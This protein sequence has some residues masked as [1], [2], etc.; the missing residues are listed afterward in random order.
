MAKLRN[1]FLKSKMNKDL[2]SRLVPT[3]EYRDALNITVGKSESASVGTAQ[4]VLG[5]SEI[6]TGGFVG[7]VLNAIGYIKDDSRNIVILFQTTYED[8][9]ETQITPAP[10]TATCRIVLVDFNGT[11]PLQTTL[12]EG[13]W[14]NLATNNQYSITGVNLVEDLL[15]W[16]D[17]RNQPRKINIETALADSAYYKHEHQISVAKYTPVEPIQL[18]KKVQTR[19]TAA[20]TTAVIS[21]AS[22]VGIEVGMFLVANTSP[23][24]NGNQYIQVISK[25]SSNVTVDNGNASFSGVTVANNQDIIFLS[26]TMTDQSSDSTWPGDPDYLEGRYVRFSYRIRYDDNEYSTFAPFTQIC[27]IPKQKGY[28]INGDEQSAFRSTILDFFENNVNNI[29]LLI[30][31]PTIGSK[32]IS[33][34]SVSEI[35]I[36]YKESDSLIVSV[37]E[38]INVSVLQNSIP[39]TNIFNYTYSSEKPYKTLPEAQTTRVYDKVP[40]RARAQEVSGNRVIY[41]NYRDNWTMPNDINYNVAVQAKTS[42][43]NNFIEYPNHTLKQNRNYQVGFILADKYNRQSSV[44]LSSNDTGTSTTGAFFGGSTIYSAYTTDTLVVKSW[45]GNALRV[46]VNSPI[47]ALNDTAAGTPGLYAN[48]ISTGLGFAVTDA[49][50]IT[51]TTYTFTLDNGGGAYPL[52]TQVPTVGSYLRGQFTDYVEVKNITGS[53]SGPYVVTTDG[54]VNDI[55]KY[56]QVNSSVANTKFAYDINPIGW[57]SYKVVVKQQEQEYYNSYLP[58]MLNA[59]PDSQTSD[60]SVKYVQSAVGSVVSLIGSGTILRLTRTES[61]EGIIIGMVATNITTPFTN[62]SPVTVTNVV[63]GTTVDVTVNQ[64]VTAG[65]TQNILF[66]ATQEL[67]EH[68][69][70]TTIFPVNEE[71]KTAHIVLI[72]D[73][74]NKI[75][76]DLT[77]VGPDQKQYRSSVELF[78]R[79]ENF[80]DTYTAPPNNSPVIINPQAVS[81]TTDTITY[82]LPAGNAITRFKSGDAIQ[83]ENGGPSGGTAVYPNGWLK[84]TV[85]VSN[86][87]NPAGTLGTIVFS[88]PQLIYGGGVSSQTD[89]FTFLREENKQYFP[90]RKADTVNTISTARDLDF[91]PNS[92]DNVRGTAALNFY[93]LDTNP[94]V[95]RISTVKG[96]GATAQ[97]MIPFLSV[98]ETKPIE[99]QLDIFW[100]T[101]STGYISDLNADV[102]TGFDGAVSLTNPGYTHRENQDATGSG[103]TTGAANSKFITNTFSS[104]DLNGNIITS[105]TMTLDSVFDFTGSGIDI[106]SRFQLI[107]SGSGGYRLA[108]QDVPFVF[109]NDAE[110][111]EKYTFNIKVTVGTTD[112]ILPIEGRLENIAPFIVN[113]CNHY[114]TQITQ[115]TTLVTTIEAKNGAHQATGASVDTVQSDVFFEILSGDQGYFEIDA[116]S[117]E[118]TTVGIVPIGFYALNIQVTD[119]YNGSPISPVNGSAFTSKTGNCGSQ[120]V[121]ITVGQEQ[122][123]QGYRN[124]QSNILTGIFNFLGT[125]NANQT[126]TPNNINPTGPVTPSGGNEFMHQTDPINTISTKV[127]RPTHLT[128]FNTG[129]SANNV[130][131]ACLYLGPHYV[132]IDTDLNSSTHGLNIDD[133][134]MPAGTSLARLPLGTDDQNGNTGLATLVNNILG[135]DVS[136]SSVSAGPYMNGKSLPQVASSSDPVGLLS[137]QLEISNKIQGTGSWIGGTSFFR[138]VSNGQINLYYKIFYRGST[139]NADGSIDYALNF[140]SS[141]NQVSDMN[142][143]VSSTG[144]TNAAGGNNANNANNPLRTKVFVGNNN[145]NS[146]GTCS[147][148]SGNCVARTASRQD[149]II[150]DGTVSPGEYCI[151][152]RIETSGGAL[153]SGTPSSGYNTQPYY[154]TGAI[155]DGNIQISTKDY[156]YNSSGNLLFPPGA[157]TAA[158]YVVNPSL[159]TGSAESIGYVNQSQDTATVNA[160]YNPSTSGYKVAT[161]AVA[162]QRLITLDDSIAVNTT[163]NPISPYLTITSTATGAIPSGTYIAKINVGGDPN[164]IEVSQDLAGTITPSAVITIGRSISSPFNNPPTNG[165]IVY[166]TQGSVNGVNQFFTDADCTVPY[167]I[168]SLDGSSNLFKVYNQRDVAGAGPGGNPARIV[169]QNLT[170]GYNNNNATNGM[171]PLD[172][173]AGSQNNRALASGKIDGTGYITNLNQNGVGNRGFSPM[174]QENTP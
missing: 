129:A 97:S 64:A 130:K 47:S 38:T 102:L 101:A 105:A 7:G 71:N 127:T 33:D 168:S 172:Y 143:S 109:N 98:Y 150:L 133:G 18:F 13:N 26:S 5:N 123:P 60:S 20:S 92:I 111:V 158:Q 80:G 57:Y 39:T 37:L 45:F 140:A 122:V 15:F 59:Y 8:P 91:L 14:L 135:S 173:G 137:G 4:N 95:A 53:G 76:R 93:Q 139:L 156:N 27:F 52:L 69:V 145:N 55:Y 126:E 162:S 28:L 16:T 114:T 22:T 141:W 152:Y 170:A 3:G 25:T 41:G 136:I 10:S 121:G 70:N 87:V 99:S 90:E 154:P 44:I 117:G 88:P 17:N 107:S 110:T 63:I 35:D 61:T 131:F 78:G 165:V 169:Y 65:A 48:P 40:V 31:L 112:T 142:G 163:D 144:W 68:G 153:P 96:I 82:N 159:T 104:V 147:T 120:I 113:G 9:S 115:A 34:Y 49:V 6:G 100:E 23:S 134:N 81:V 83:A 167:S 157:S 46:L 89:S 75:P 30:P 124:P 138:N 2:D 12:V 116:Q 108:I 125:A 103:T 54:Q 94:L 155:A 24:I 119:A 106:S 174:T 42:Q 85:I 11:A 74:I 62:A 1:T 132:H 149:T 21:V 51:P 56:D 166:S 171:P 164:T 128:A 36:L 58:G 118:I 86:T 73:N 77:E 148:S 72:N 79:V 66:T 50:T 161:N 32:L 84:D 67:I 160:T 43:F 19:T 29:E 151:I 146:F